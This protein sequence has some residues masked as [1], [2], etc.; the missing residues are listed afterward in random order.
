MSTI[1]Y[2]VLCCFFSVPVKNLEHL[3][4][5]FFHIY[6]KINELSLKKQI[7]MQWI[8]EC[9]AAIPAFTRKRNTRWVNHL[10]LL[11]INETHCRKNPP[12]TKNCD[13]H[14]SVNYNYLMKN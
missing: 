1:I 9:S 11:F 12:F 13:P 10:L 6:S 5:E 8:F 7:K 4:M 3:F 14:P 2:T